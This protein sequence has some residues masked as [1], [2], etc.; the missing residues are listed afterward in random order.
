MAPWTPDGERLSPPFS[1]DSAASSSGRNPIQTI[2]R[3]NEQPLPLRHCPGLALAIVV[4]SLLTASFAWTRD[5]EVGG[6]P[7]RGDAVVRFP[8]GPLAPA[9]QDPNIDYDLQPAGEAFFVHIPPAYSGTERYGLI[10][11][12]DPKDRVGAEPPGWADVLDRRKFLFVAPQDAGNGQRGE[13]RR[14]LAVLA[15][16][17]MS[18]RYAVDPQRVYV[19]G[20]S[21]GARIAS[22]LG[23][24]QSDLFHGTIQSCGTD[25]YRH[26]PQ[27]AATTAFDTTGR[28]YGFVD[29]TP[30]EIRDAQR[31]RFALIT[32]DR[33]FRH[34]NILD[35]YN[36]GF[37]KSG[38]QVRLFD[39][40][41]MTHTNADAA[42]LDAA[43]S[44][45][46]ARP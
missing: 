28:A 1:G 33:D 43:L 21:G 20:L 13:R 23:F 8:G 11:Y 45:V 34:G 12:M 41:G 35:L 30:E 24:F 29:A 37:A 9:R 15:A 38:L 14:G 26:V 25:F 31:V 3:R 18:R 36:G 6:P 16:L 7:Q 4:A 22:Q 39:V 27:V 10:V 40:P 17:E 44:F 46:D 32:G 2:R 42:T 19:A 5:L